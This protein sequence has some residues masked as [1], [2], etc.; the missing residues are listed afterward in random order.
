MNRLF[1]ILLLPVVATFGALGGSVISGVAGAG[2]GDYLGRQRERAG[3]VEYEDDSPAFLGPVGGVMGLIGG[4]IGGT[5]GAIA[6]WISNKGS[7]GAVAGPLPLLLFI[8]Y[9]AFG[10]S[11]NNF[12]NYAGLIICLAIALSG[13]PLVGAVAGIWA[14]FSTSPGRVRQG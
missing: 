1:H 9:R 8:F 14:K 12:G 2:T 6:G 7:W 13:P 10:E 4:A 11:L 3:L 5:I